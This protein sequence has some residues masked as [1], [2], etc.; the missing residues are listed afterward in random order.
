MTSVTTN[1]IGG[2]KASVAVKP[3]GC[4]RR[5]AFAKIYLL[6]WKVRFE[7]MSFWKKE[8]IRA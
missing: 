2:R 5:Q 1:C 8:A 6:L 4:G 3:G 7:K